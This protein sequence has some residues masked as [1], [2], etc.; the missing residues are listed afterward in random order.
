M[1]SEQAGVSS[2]AMAYLRFSPDKTE[3][4]FMPDEIQ[5]AEKHLKNLIGQ[6]GVLPEKPAYRAHQSRIIPVPQNSP[7]ALPQAEQL[8]SIFKKYGKEIDLDASPVT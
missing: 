3:R 5:S 6:Q 2:G 4:I 1:L 8:V 7:S